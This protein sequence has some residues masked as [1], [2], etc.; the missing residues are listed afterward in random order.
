MG[1]MA[2]IS[3]GAERRSMM[4]MMSMMYTCLPRIFTAGFGFLLHF[5]LCQIHPTYMLL[6]ILAI[7]GTRCRGRGK[8]LVLVLLSCLLAG[9]RPVCAMKLAGSKI[10]TNSHELPFRSEGA[11]LGLAI[12][13]YKGWRRLCPVGSLRDGPTS[14]GRKRELHREAGRA[15]KTMCQVSAWVYC[16]QQWHKTCPHCK[17]RWHSC[18]CSIRI[19]PRGWHSSCD[20]T[21]LGATDLNWNEH[22]PDDLRIWQIIRIV[23]TIKGY[24]YKDF[25][26]LSHTHYD[27]KLL[28]FWNM[29]ETKFGTALNDS[30][31]ILYMFSAPWCCHSYIGQTGGNGWTRLQSHRY[32]SLSKKPGKL[33]DKMRQMHFSSFV[34]VPLC[35][36]SVAA[37]SVAD[38]LFIEAQAIALWKPSLNVQGVISQ[39]TYNNE[40]MSIVAPRRIQSRVLMHARGLLQQ[41]P[42]LLFSTSAIL[43]PREHVD[44]RGWRHRL[45]VAVSIGRRP[46]LQK[47]GLNSE[48]VRVVQSW[49]PMYQVRITNTALRCLGIHHR[50]IFLQN[51]SKCLRTFTFKRVVINSEVGFSACVRKALHQQLTM[52]V[53]VAY[54][55][56]SALNVLKLCVRSRP[57]PSLLDLAENSR[58]FLQ[59]DAEPT[60]CCCHQSASAG[61]QL[62]EGHVCDNFQGVSRLLA[63]EWPTSWT[64]RS[65]FTPLADDVCADLAF[66]FQM[67]CATVL[68]TSQMS[69]FNSPAMQQACDIALAKFRGHPCIFRGRLIASVISKFV[70]VPVD[71]AKGEIAILCPKMYWQISQRFLRNYQCVPVSLPEVMRF[72]EEFFVWPNKLEVLPFCGLTSGCNH[73]FGSLTLHIKAKSIF[74]LCDGWTNLKL[75][76]L[77]SYRKH[78]W[79]NLLSIT[80]RALNYIQESVAPGF[81]TLCAPS[82]RRKVNSFNGNS[83]LLFGDDGSSATLH[84]DDI[85]DFFT[86]APRDEVIDAV[87]WAC[88]QLRSQSGHEY[89]CI[90]R[91]ARTPKQDAWLFAE[92]PGGDGWRQTRGKR[93]PTTMTTSVPLD[94]R[95]FHCLAIHDI[96]GILAH[97]WK[98]AF[99]LMGGVLYKQRTGFAQGSP[100]S[101]GAANLFAA[102]REEKWL[103]SKSVAVRHHISVHLC[104]ARWMDDR[105]LIWRPGLYLHLLRE[106]L[107]PLFYATA[108]RLKP[109]CDNKF[110]GLRVFCFQG[111]ICTLPW[112]SSCDMIFLNHPVRAGRLMS[113]SSFGSRSSVNG[114]LLGHA[115]RVLDFS[116]GNKSALFAALLLLVTELQH[117]GHPHMQLF[118]LMWQIHVKMPFLNVTCLLRGKPGYHSC[119]AWHI[120][121]A[122]S[123]Q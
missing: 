25:L 109:T 9:P 121:A 106:L 17:C 79:R 118:R 112:P 47:R 95:K 16:K 89:I 90:P 8:V 53:T 73:Q 38:R 77:V 39:D 60:H 107:N 44:L 14:V 43:A 48:L 122:C 110:I 85:E 105:L 115:V 91:A 99:F 92:K 24:F 80:C 70:C 101:S 97:D 19:A 58:R 32:A 63:P 49:H 83:H 117:A 33:Y 76:P 84:V 74:P 23:E 37:T 5:W 28:A 82:F 93:T 78:H 88:V 65:R 86:K 34:F 116:I 12:Q 29:L 123:S 61:W 102:V 100:V 87:H 21:A 45:A 22:T 3:K 62:L 96:P 66:Q 108:C 52:A 71:R 46:I 51:M 68:S 64:A 27:R 54:K 1:S 57:T 67:V 2:S 59:L 75:R 10:W 4:M 50:A 35:D 55:E 72:T 41:V 111:N 69:V 13:C 42:H 98:F 6:A 30:A 20:I 120:L 15:L 81:V 94:P 40:Y 56:T 11:M 7:C 114:R 113:N 119:V 36:L 31:G 18:Q 103:R 104:A 26:T